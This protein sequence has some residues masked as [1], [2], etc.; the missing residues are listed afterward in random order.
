MLLKSCS[1][2]DV[3]EA[4]EDV[5]RSVSIGAG[6]NFFLLWFL[7]AVVYFT[8]LWQY[9]HWEGQRFRLLGQETELGSKQPNP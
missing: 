9:Q 8:V 1:V 6:L 3:P 7:Q 2:L 4:S 5:W